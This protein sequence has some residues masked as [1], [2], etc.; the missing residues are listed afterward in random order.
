MKSNLIFLK[1]VKKN[2]KNSVTLKSGTDGVILPYLIYQ[3]V[4]NEPEGPTENKV[5]NNNLFDIKQ[6][7]R[8]KFKEPEFFEEQLPNEFNNPDPSG[9]GILKTTKKN[10]NIYMTLKSSMKV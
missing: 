3:T 2:S 5:P 4:K 1:N 9:R 10:S 8:T 7:W 6:K